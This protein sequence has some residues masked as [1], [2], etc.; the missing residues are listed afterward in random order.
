M[1]C[2][3]LGHSERVS[4][5]KVSTIA[6]CV[7]VNRHF[8]WLQVLLLVKEH[9]HNH[10]AFLRSSSSNPCILHSELPLDVSNSSPIIKSIGWKV[11]KICEEQLSSIYVQT[12]VHTNTHT[13]KHSYIQT[14]TYICVASQQ[15]GPEFESRSNIEMVLG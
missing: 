3:V 14:H 15:E 4:V 13:C 2:S 8:V 5:W 9:N 6:A 12:Y 7:F 11:L 1:A 10:A